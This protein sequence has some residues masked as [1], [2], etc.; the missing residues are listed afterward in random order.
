MK[1]NEKKIVLEIDLE[2]R[3][4]FFSKYND[5]SL[6]PELKEYIINELVGNDPDSKLVLEINSKYDVSED[7]KEAYELAI[8]KEFRET[9]FE[10]KYE[11]KLDYTRN[12]ILFFIG[13]LLI[14]ISN[15]IDVSIL[16]FFKEILLVFGWFAL[17]QIAYIVFY[18]FMV[19]RRNVRRLKQVLMSKIVF[20]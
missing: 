5:R 2:S 12:L 10:I 19:R 14:L 3:Y 16:G 20:K 13:V 18:S 4:D 1:K 6:A 8:R 11:A 15:F 9:M 7:D 17:T